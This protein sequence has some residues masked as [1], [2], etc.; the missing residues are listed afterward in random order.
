MAST[1]IIQALIA[2][3]GYLVYHQLL[4]KPKRNLPPGPKGLPLVGNVLNLPPKDVPDHVH[5]RS[6]TDEY[7]PVASVTLL[8][9]PMIFVADRQ[10][11]QEILEKKSA[12]S[13]GRPAFPFANYCGFADFINMY[14]LD[15]K[16][17]TAQRKAMHRAIGT[18]ALASKYAEMQEREAGRLL[19]RTLAESDKVV[20]HIE[21]EAG[22]VILKIVYGYTIN[23]RG[24]DPLIGLIERMMANFSRACVPFARLVDFVPALERLPAGFPGTGFK[25]EAAQ[26]GREIRA[27]VDEPYEFARRRLS[28]HGVTGSYV[29]RLVEECAG[30]AGELSEEDAHTIKWSAAALYAGGADTTV[31]VLI[32][33]ILAMTMF[34]GVQ[35]KA[36]EEVDRVTGGTRIPVLADRDQ[37]PYVEAMVSE[38]LRWCPILPMGVPHAMSED[39]SYRGYDLPKGAYLLPAIWG[40]AHDPCVYADPDDFAPERFLAPRNEPDPRWAVFGFGRRVC[41]GRYLADSSLFLN[42]AALVAVFNIDK[43]TDDRG[44]VMEPRLEFEA[45]LIAKPKPFPFSITPR[46]EGHAELIRGF[47]R[48]HPWEESD[49][50]L[51][52]ELPPPSH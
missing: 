22:A 47:E 46:S 26:Y 30:E 50:A 29:A 15:D 39:V 43:A 13:S 11:A 10:A 36:Q 25:A 12:V 14:Q 2:L 42:L 34:P 35:Q 51:L 3:A 27:V 17:F 21:T 28:E 18:K 7:G 9:Q 40:F 33:F 19:V 49:A 4:R 31:S 52:G 16:R 32:S 45:G 20:K 41:P 6:I 1:L 24:F 38:A 5:W 37:M 48:E 23:P 8:G 44:N